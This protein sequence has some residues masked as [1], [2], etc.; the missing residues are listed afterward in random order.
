M[1]QYESVPLSFCVSVAHARPRRVP[2]VLGQLGRLKLVHHD[3]RQ[4]GGGGYSLSERGLDVLALSGMFRRGIVMDVGRRWGGGKESDL[5][6]GEAKGVGV[7]LKFHHLGHTSFKTARTKRV[8]GGTM[9]LGDDGASTSA[10]LY[11]TERQAARQ[12]W[13]RMSRASAEREYSIMEALYSRSFTCYDGT[14]LEHF[15][16]PRVLGLDR[17]CIAMEFVDGTTLACIAGMK[18]TEESQNEEEEEETVEKEIKQ[19]N[20]NKTE[21][22]TYEFSKPLNGTLIVAKDPTNL[23]LQALALILNCLR[24]GIIHGDVSEYNII[25]R[26]KGDNL[27]LVLIDFPQCEPVNEASRTILARDIGNVD[28]FFRRWQGFKS[29]ESFPESVK[30]MESQIWD[31]FES[32]LKT[33]AEKRKQED[34][35]RQERIKSGAAVQSMYRAKTHGQYTDKEVAKRLKEQRSRKYKK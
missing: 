20:H 14:V 15:P 5:Y 7:I 16:I 32:I 35:E 4:Q 19:E 9:L 1:G 22:K 3:A 8:Y 24:C 30:T 25:A 13:A 28:S 23:H 31:L 6:L 17:H 33:E 26:E 34:E 18:E 27:E 12:D 11:R 10:V 29:D 21:K 2:Q